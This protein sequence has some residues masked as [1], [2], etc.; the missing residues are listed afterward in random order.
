[1][2]I[3]AIS[4]YSDYRGYILKKLLLC[5]ILCAGLIPSVFA[6]SSWDDDD[7]FGSDK[8]FGITPG[9]RL[10]ILGLEPTL[11]LDISHLEL[12]AA[13]V[14]NTGFDGKQFAYAPSCSIAYITNPFEKG[15]STAFGLEYMYLTPAYTAMMEKLVDADSSGLYPGVHGLSLFYKGCYNFNSVVGLLWRLRLPVMI[16]G[17][18]GDNYYNLNITNLPGFAGCFLLGICTTTI[19]VKFTF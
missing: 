17:K 9:V 3:R 5:L 7:D 8:T 14:F 2:R 15:G 19:G 18:E 1:M 11:A 13:C 10:S 4:R 16:M 6:R 12:E